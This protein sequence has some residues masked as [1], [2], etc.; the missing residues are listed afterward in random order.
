MR[1]HPLW[2]V[3]VSY[4]ISFVYA[5][6]HVTISNET[7][8][9]RSAA[10]G[11]RISH[12]GKIGFIVEP[13]QDPTGC[14]IVEPPCSDWIALVK[15]GGCSF[16]TKVRYMQ[17]SGAVAVVVGD[18]EHPGWITMYAPGDTSDVTIPSVFL[19][20]KEYNK[21]LQLSKLLDTPMMAVLQYDDVVTW[22]LIDILIIVVVSP[23]I[24]LF[25]IYISWKIRQGVQRRRELAPVSVV[26]KLTV[27]IFKL[28]EK[29]QEPDSCAICLEDYQSGNELRLLPCNHQ[30]HTLCVDAWLTTQKKLCPICKRDITADASSYTN[31]RDEVTPL[32]LS[33]DAADNMV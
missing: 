18:P 16:I 12:N 11:P 30:F 9:D 7:F 25:L 22:P 2:L 14:S 1:S 4:F 5:S 13:S 19:A 23:L 6:T 32:L 29:E 3:L 24:M 8:E 26:S 33:S 28:D 27:K 20:M 10:F 21:I 31:K 17:K 15:R